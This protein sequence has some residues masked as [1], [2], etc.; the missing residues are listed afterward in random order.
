MERV[1]NDQG[2]TEN[3]T[4]KMEQIKE[5][6]TDMIVLSTVLSMCV[7]TTP[8]I[9]LTLVVASIP[10]GALS[11]CKVSARVNLESV[12]T[13]PYQSATLSSRALD[14]RMSPPMNINQMFEWM[15]ADQSKR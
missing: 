5:A 10:N 8:I 15:D 14:T 3:K 1:R 12:L 2:G 4:I 13:L 6:L 9:R 11:N 7:G